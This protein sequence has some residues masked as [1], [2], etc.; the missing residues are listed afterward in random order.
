MFGVCASNRTRFS[1][2][3]SA[4]ALAIIAAAP[5]SAQVLYGSIV[6][7]VQDSSGA[8][9][10]SASVVFTDAATGQNRSTTSN[11]A[12]LYS[13]TNVLAGTY[14]LKVTATGFKPFVQTNVAVTVNNVA[15]IDV[16]LE[17]GAATE[18]VTVEATAALL[19]SDTA[20][21]H[22]QLNS[23]EV[24]DLPL[25]NYRNYQSLINLVP[26]ATPSDQQNS[27]LGAPAR[28]LATNINGTN[29]NNN[30][31]RLDGAVNLYLWLPHHT[32]YVAPS[33]TV[34]TVSVSTNN[35][36]AEQ[37]MAGGAAITVV[38][39]S[40]TNQLHGSA[41]GYHTNNHLKAKNFF[42]VGNLPRSTRNIDGG[43]IG[44]PIVKDKLFFFGGWEG[45]RERQE[46]SGTYT[47]PTAD[48]RAGNFSAYGTTLY[49]PLSG[50]ADGRS[51]TPFPNATIPADR[52]SPNALKMQGLLPSPNLP[53]A[54]SNYF[55]SGTLK[56]NRDNYDVKVNW[57]RSSQHALFVKYSA[58]NGNVN[59]AFAF[60]EGGG[61]ALGACGAPGKGHTLVQISTIGHT[62]TIS[63]RFVVD[64]TIGWTRMTQQGQSP[65]FG[66]NVGLD[67]LG[68]PGTNGPDPRQSG[69]PGFNVSGYSGFGN[70]DNPRPNFYADQ[71]YTTSHNASYSAGKHE[72]R[73]GFD[74]VRHQLNHWQPELNNP[75]GGF[76]FGGGVTALSGGTAPN[77]FNSYAAFLLGLPTNAG[78]SL[79]YLTMTGREWQLGWYVR[80]RWQV[81]PHLTL[82]LGL[83]YEYYP[84]MTRAD[85][86]LERYDPTTNQ[87][88]IGRRGGNP[89]NVGIDV[90]SRFFAPRVGFAYRLG[91]DTVIRSGYGITYDP[92]PFSRPLRGPYPATI[93]QNFVGPNTFTPFASLAQGIPLF[94]G[95]DLSS[96]SV[97]LPPTVD[98]RSPWAGALHRGYIQSWNFIVERKLPGDL[99]GSIGYVGTQTVHAL[100]DRDINAAQPGAGNTGRPLYA[101]FRRTAATTMWD[102]FLNA[103]YHAF[104][105]SVN[106]RFK[107]GVLIKGAY[108]FSKSISST[109]EDGWAGLSWNSDNVIRRN[110]SLTGY[111][112]THVVQFGWVADLPFGPGKRFASQGGPVSWVVRDWQAN[113]TFSA[114]SGVPFT[115]SADGSSLNAPGNTQ[116]ADQVKTA[117]EKLGGIGR[118]VAF[119]DPLAFRAITDV[120][121]GSSGR[122][123]LRGPGVVNADLSIFRTFPIAERFKLQ[124]RAEAF[125]VTNTPHFNNPGANVSNMRLNADGTINTLG[126]FLSVT[127]ARADERN[128]RFALRLTF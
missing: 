86:G 105:A 9:V 107:G 38:T 57:N 60:G 6:G 59:C 121:Y 42:F 15:R 66:K 8:M 36:D 91:A 125:N 14:Q 67:F 21:V 51:R 47:L 13:F 116:T 84:L 35:F 80:D 22:V 123:I 93:A 19:Q 18:Q 103:N 4:L 50:A 26:G 52:L 126:N 81:T 109:D 72:F 12:G 7:T 25:S 100:A 87:V 118:N 65:D 2:A 17:V 3:V 39:K 96:G 110:R 127:S 120:R 117:V 33:E 64:G 70:T 69:T 34:E 99:G 124:F 53:G 23:K 29:K 111:D 28:A 32:A 97:E 11:E 71:S 95:P 101:A 113:G 10:P 92:L 55:N 68:I 76:T 56:F 30:I 104:Q 24:T 37:G 88:L 27:L 1:L 102:G 106:R 79:Q 40:G 49:D 75:R 112:R 48:Q 46:A 74:L 16:R 83:R 77:Q 128:F 58:M 122:N 89:D 62:L 41:F 43:T 98:N 5:A 94:S 45:M 119:F 114:Y 31:T 82:S 115:V 78:K 54:V 44:G 73:F 20:D 61:D 108:T 63:P 85:R 90:S